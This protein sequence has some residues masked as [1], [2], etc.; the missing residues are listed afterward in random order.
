MA[1][2][3][4]GQACS[5]ECKGQDENLSL[6]LDS[7][8]NLGSGGNDQ[9]PTNV[10]VGINY[11]QKSTGFFEPQGEDVVQGATN[12][13]VEV[14][15]DDMSITH[16]SIDNDPRLHALI[17]QNILLNLNQE[18]ADFDSNRVVSGT[19]F[20]IWQRGFGTTDTA[21][22][23]S[24]DA[25]G[26]MDVNE[27]DLFIWRAQF[28][29]GAGPQLSA[30]AVPEPSTSTLF[31]SLAIAGLLARYRHGSITFRFVDCSWLKLS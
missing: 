18:N 20:L 16:T 9:L 15:F 4:S 1:S 7:V 3:L 22:L 23:S 13:N 25:N 26:D 27:E 21:I 19:D 28:G 6:Q 31:S 11:Y 14:L 10:D 29:D 12:I 24:G 8:T 5:G 17:G 30:H 2:D